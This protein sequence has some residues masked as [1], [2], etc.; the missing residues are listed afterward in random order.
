MIE[1]EQAN[2][3]LLFFYYICISANISKVIFYQ[4]LPKTYLY[5]WLYSQ[6]PHKFKLKNAVVTV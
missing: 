4:K 2:L 3:K 1:K 5:I 6:K